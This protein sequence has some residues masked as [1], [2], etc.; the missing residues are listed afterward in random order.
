MKKE[1]YIFFGIL[2]MLGILLLPNV[3]AA[4]SLK[5]SLSKFEPNPAAPGQTV[6]IWLLVENTG[7]EDAKNINVNVVPDFPFSIYGDTPNKT[8]TTL[9]AAKDYLIDFTLKVD[10]AALSGDN[11]LK[12][13]FIDSTRNTLSETTIKIPVQSRDTTI[14]IDSV[15]TEPSEIEPGSDGKVTISVKNMA[16]TS[17]TD[18][19]LRLY[20]QANIGSTFI[21]LPFAPLDSGSEKRIYRIDPNQIVDFTYDLKAYPDAASKVYKIPFLLTYYASQGNQQNK[22][23]Y[24]G[25]VVNSA[26]EIS[27]I[28]DKTDILSNKRSGLLTIKFVNKG[29]SD[30]KFLNVIMQKSNDYNLLSDSDTTYVGNLVSDDYQTVDYTMDITSTKG[31]INIPVELQYRDADNK[32]YDTI[33]NVTLNIIDSSKLNQAS[34]KSSNVSLIIII[35][36]VVAIGV[37]IYFRSRSKK[38]KKAQFG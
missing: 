13:Q 12:V 36:I 37:W 9:G 15:K 35:V 30:V 14:S 38:N 31:T 26:P 6:K 23:D 22:S 7:D 33:E 24:I 17:F 20:L 34:G 3:N 11:N 10:N 2:F 5:V 16:Q 28:V 29:L 18:L 21:D 1:K 19:N 32:Y 4:A 27:A 8:I 25:I